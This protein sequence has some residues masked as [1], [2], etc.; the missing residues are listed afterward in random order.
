MLIANYLCDM[1]YGVLSAVLKNS[2]GQFNLVSQINMKVS[3]DIFNSII[4]MF[5]RSKPVFLDI[6][7]ICSNTY[8]LHS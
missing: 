2:F 6:E 1:H 4:S 5:F 3:I 7:I 8:N